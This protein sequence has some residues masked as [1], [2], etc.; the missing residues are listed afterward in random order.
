MTN[1]DFS[2]AP[3]ARTLAALASRGANG[4]LVVTTTYRTVNF[5]FVDGEVVGVQSSRPSDRLGLQLMKSGTIGAIDLHEAL[6]EQHQQRLRAIASSSS[7]SRLGDILLDLDILDTAELG[8]ALDRHTQS[9]ID[10]LNSD[11]VTSIEFAVWDRA[12]TERLAVR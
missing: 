10:S 7:P 11:V 12:Q 4:T 2:R 6:I 3:L 9:M 5:R 8:T 1:P